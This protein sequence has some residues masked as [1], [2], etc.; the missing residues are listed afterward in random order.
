M[1]KIKRSKLTPSVKMG[2][3]KDAFCAFSKRKFDRTLGGLR[4]MKKTGSEKSEPM[5]NVGECGKS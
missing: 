1:K 4:I 2:F 3:L 5:V